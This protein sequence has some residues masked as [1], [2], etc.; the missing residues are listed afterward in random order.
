MDQVPVGLVFPGQGTQK[1]GM[2]EVWRDT[3]SWHLAEEISEVTGEDLPEL[4]L[5]TP[6]EHLRRTDLAQL[7]VFTVTMMAHAEAVRGD[8]FGG[9]VVA[10]AGHSLGEYA[11]LVASGAL[12]VTRAAALV[13][14]RGRAM[15]EAALAHEGR[16]GAVVGVPPEEVAALADEI[17]GEGGEV[18]VANINAPAQT[19]ISGS[20]ASVAEFGGRAPAIGA[21]MI[22][23]EVGG[24]FHT[25]FMAPAA[26]ALGRALQGTPFAPT[27]VPVVANVD[28]A[29]YRGNVDWPALCVRQLTSPVLWEQSVRTLTGQL[30]CRRFVELGPGRT[31]AGLIRRI[32]RNVEVVSSDV[33]GALLTRRVS[34]R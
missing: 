17:R 3:P 32:D 18:W 31:L 28:A 34:E 8:S 6:Q 27:A 5:R 30:G 24:A 12:A 25:P 15:R 4:L 22:A 14:A 33:S 21:R 20:P 13:T 16:M 1:Q 23:M 10:C 11:A 26:E 7:T 2:G 19:V 9:P 29:P